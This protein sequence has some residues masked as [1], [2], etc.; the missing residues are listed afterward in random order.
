METVLETLGW[1]AF[2]HGVLIATMLIP[3][4]TVIP[5]IMI[6]TFFICVYA[7]D[8]LQIVPIPWVRVEIIFCLVSPL[9]VTTYFCATRL[10]DMRCAAAQHSEAC[11]H[12]EKT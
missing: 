1:S 11:W 9:T 7:A 12:G 8:R 2:V 5:F 3:L 10:L 4:L 6:V